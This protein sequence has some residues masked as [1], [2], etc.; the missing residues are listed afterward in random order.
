MINKNHG[1]NLLVVTFT[2]SCAEYE[3][4]EDEA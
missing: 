2:E 3:E 4:Y 1:F